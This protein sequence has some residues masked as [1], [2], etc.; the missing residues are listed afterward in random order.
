MATQKKVVPEELIIIGH[1][2]RT[3][4]GEENIGYGMARKYLLYHLL[5]TPISLAISWFIAP[6]INPLLSVG[7][8]ALI[9]T[10]PM[11]IFPF[12]I[13]ASRKTGFYILDDQADRL[14]F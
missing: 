3:R 5:A 7:K 1:W 11:L 12:F 10:L 14:A 4:A 6:R 13:P 8:R 9:T 2:P